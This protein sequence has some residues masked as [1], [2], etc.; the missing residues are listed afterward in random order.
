MAIISVYNI[1]WLVF[2]TE[3]ESVYCAV[4]TG[5]LKAVQGKFSF[6]MWMQLWQ[7][8]LIV[9]TALALV[10]GNVRGLY[11]SFAPLL[12][13]SPYASGRSCD[14]PTD[15]LDSLHLPYRHMPWRCQRS[16]VATVWFFCS[17]RN[18]SLS[19]WASLKYTNYC[20][21]FRALALIRNK[22]FAALIVSHCC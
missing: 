9:S 1:N 14:W 6:V 4:R 13:T 22:N 5:F 10:L 19:R 11:L 7:V 20:S 17:L 18:L 15:Q 16:Q 3:T 8:I 12:A 2:I 21:K